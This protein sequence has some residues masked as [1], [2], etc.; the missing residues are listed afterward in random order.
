MK[1][2]RYI[3]TLAGV[4]LLTHNIFANDYD[5]RKTRWGMSIYEVKQTEDKTQ[6]LVF[7]K[8]ENTSD[9]I[10]IYYYHKKSPTT[11][12]FYKFTRQGLVASGVVFYSLTYRDL[13]SMFKTSMLELDARFDRH[14]DL[15]TVSKPT[16]ANSRTVTQIFK[17]RNYLGISVISLKHVSK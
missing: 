3:T 14:K 6:E 12:V 17:G 9:Y 15:D 8:Q 11:E 13:Q 5:F 2:V 10:T 4:L 7:D 1:Y 16:W